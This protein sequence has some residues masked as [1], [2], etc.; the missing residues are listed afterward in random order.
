MSALK[1]LLKS[2]DK[3]V[4]LDRSVGLTSLDIA[5]A[6]YFNTQQAS[7]DPRHLWL[8]ALTSYQWGRGH[9]CLD[10]HALQSQANALL[11]WNDEQISVLPDN[12][13]AGASSLP[14][15]QG[16]S[17]P[18]VLVND[19]QGD[20]L[21]LRRAWAAEQ[22]I[23]QHILQRINLPI[24][25]PADLKTQ[26]DT[27]FGKDTSMQRVACEVAT[28]NRIT[29][30]TGGPGT[31]KT[32]TVVKLLALLIRTSLDTLKIHLAAP[33]GKAAARLTE[34]IA[35]ALPLMP[36]AEQ[37]R[38]PNQTQTL[39]RLLRS[40][41]RD[42][43]VH[44]LATD[45]VVVD[46]ASM[47]DL[48]MMAR[49]LA[50][51][52]PSA[53]LILLGDK[54]QLASVEAGAVMSQLCTGELL[55]AQTVTLT[56]SHR[57][58]T[59]SGIGQ[60]AQAV[61]ADNQNNTGAIQSLW[62]A[63]P[64][65]LSILQTGTFEEHKGKQ[66]PESTSPL[67][68]VSR[69]QLPNAHDAKLT[70]ALRH[71]W[72][73]WLSLLNEHRSDISGQT[74]ACTDSQANEL[75][76]AFSEFSVL[77]AVREGPFGVTQ[78]NTQIEKSLGFNPATWY[79]GRPIM[80][81]RNDYALELMNGDVGICLPGPNGVL[82]VAFPGLSGSVRWIVPSRLDS[83]ETVFAMTVHKSQGS[84][85]KHVLLVVPAQ[86]SPVLT[87]ELIYTGLTRARED[88]TIWAPRKEVLLQACSRRVLR[89]GGLGAG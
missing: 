10:L 56:H 18:M 85:F 44:Q 83:V 75:L 17:S 79:V 36:V 50:S 30:I 1:D 20:R 71:G 60:W 16:D 82:R 22:S 7:D 74:A 84:E 78:L 43:R 46:E 14:W 35:N 3:P 63:A 77:C 6:N 86:D 81:T 37:S 21:Y 34:S 53:R 47:V 23:R 52:P 68:R 76:T 32:T 61:N 73:P 58:D 8:A 57:F 41:S 24:K 89:S 45:V 19:A 40:N 87:R 33:T 66:G 26:L 25:E 65:W 12:L 64:D 70:P 67:H 4:Q 27:L 42:T 11:G 28:K 88:L 59:T 2:F 9:A 48:E 31:G 54:D 29:L 49:L 55:R 62:N 39:H 51:V 5:L 72:R 38:I 15:I 13:S 69:L 80:V